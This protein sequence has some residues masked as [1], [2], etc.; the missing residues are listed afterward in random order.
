[1]RATVHHGDVARPVA[2]ASATFMVF[3]Q[4]QSGMVPGADKARPP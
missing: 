1:V 4:G 2:V 3:Q